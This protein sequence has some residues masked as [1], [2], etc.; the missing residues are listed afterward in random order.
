MLSL[1]TVWELQGLSETER[2]L[3]DEKYSFLGG[4]VTMSQVLVTAGF[5][6]GEKPVM[7][8]GGSADI[9]LS[10]LSELGLDS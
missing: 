10:A 4:A 8:V 5:F 7:A 3:P 1:L 9:V 6:Q 2:E